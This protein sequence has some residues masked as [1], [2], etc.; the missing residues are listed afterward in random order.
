MSDRA[1][2]LIEGVEYPIPSRYRLGDPVL[3]EEIS[4]L[5][6]EEF[7]IRL[8]SGGWYQG[9]DPAVLTGVIAVAVWQANQNWSREKARRYVERIAQD[10]FEWKLPEQKADDADPP[11]G[12]TEDPSLSPSTDSSATSTST[13]GTSETEPAPE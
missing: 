12:A 3:I 13:A 6:F 8:S 9:V 4:G 7:S 5:T 2:F 1:A 11:E 10:G